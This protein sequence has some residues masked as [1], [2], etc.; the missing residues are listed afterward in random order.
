MTISTHI[1]TNGRP[2]PPVIVLAFAAYNTV[3]RNGGSADDAIGVYMT[4]IDDR[5]MHPTWLHRGEDIRFDFDWIH[6]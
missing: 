2:F 3:I 1:E 6:F 4:G 5:L